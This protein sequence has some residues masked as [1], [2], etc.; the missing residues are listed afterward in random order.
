MTGHEIAQRRSYARAMLERGCRVASV[1]TMVSARFS[2]SRSTAYAD[3][4]AASEEISASDDGPG[5][6]ETSQPLD[7][8]TIQGQLAHLIDVAA[9]AGDIK[10]ICQLVKAADAAKRWQGYQA[11][12]GGWV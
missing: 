6:L 8:E 12:Q 11:S 5:S 10:G 9:A 7:A 1:A 3:V 4:R 2:V